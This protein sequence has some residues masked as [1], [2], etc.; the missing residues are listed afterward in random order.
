M[1]KH[2]FEIFYGVPYAL[3]LLSETDQGLDTLRELKLVMFGGS[4]C[5]DAL[6]DKLVRY[7]VN[8]ISHYGTTETGQL[9]TSFRG[10]GDKDWNYL[11]VSKTLEP[12]IRWE[13]RGGG[14]FELVVLPGWPSKVATNRDD[15]AY[16]TKDLFSVHPDNSNAF[17]WSGRLDDTLVLVNGEK[18][19]PIPIEHTVRENAF[20]AEAVVFGSGKPLLGMLV[21]PSGKTRGMSHGEIMQQILP[22]VQIANA[23]QPAYAQISPEMIRILAEDTAYPKTDKDTV[24]RAA[25]YNKFK[26]P[27]ERVY[28]D[29]FDNTTGAEEMNRTELTEFLTAAVAEVMALEN[30][31]SLKVD[32]DFFTVGMDSLQAMRIQLAISKK[33]NTN[34]KPLKQNTV[35]EHPSIQSLVD[36]L[37][38]LKT[39]VAIKSRGT[40]EVMRDLLEKY[41]Q[42]EEHK[43]ETSA[44]FTNAIL[45]TG[46][47]GSLGA[48]V[49]AQMVHNASVD[50][51]YCLVR[52]T[53]SR[54]AAQ[55]VVE[56]MVQRR[57]YHN[58]TARERS[59]IVSLPSDFSRQDLGLEPLVYNEV[60]R[61]V[62]LVV[63]LA[64]AVNFN[65]GVE[66]FERQHIAGI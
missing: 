57:V 6:G 24:M 9:M 27:I 26:D 42:F 51:V 47:T 62:S 29:Y 20:V 19:I 17:K 31:D 49:V 2:K 37:W 43:P 50:K 12:F 39:G 60:T 1:T 35:F 21:V 18:A 52:A 54:N 33:L 8:L 48:H 4:S 14:L 30:A 56:S 61:N 7:G 23:D 16:A 25:F 22:S 66:S 55:R 40:E 65:M 36:Y 15:G 28:A 34:G 13:E 44:D 59:K 64:W 38:F 63:H 53:S 41:S 46:A 45:V 32:T 5:P 3:K 10:D 11:R 58:L